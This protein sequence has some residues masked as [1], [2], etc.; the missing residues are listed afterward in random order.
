[1]RII[2][3]SIFALFMAAMVPSVGAAEPV[4]EP[5]PTVRDNS[6]QIIEDYYAALFDREYDRALQ[7]AKRLKPEPSNVEGRAL[8]TAMRAN[9][10]LGLG[11]RAEADRLIAE[12]K[13]LG[14]KEPFPVTTLFIG[15]MVANKIDVAADA[16]DDL[17]AR[18]PDV[19]REQNVEMVGFFLRDE[20]KGEV[21]RNEDRRIALARLGYGGDT[22]NGHLLTHQAIK[23]LMKRGDVGGARNLIPYL[24]EPQLME[25]LLIQKRFAAL[26]PDL[27]QAAGPHLSKVQE[28]LVRSAQQAYE[29]TPDD[30]DRLPLYANA[31]RHAGRLSDAIALRSKLPQTADEMS[32]ADQQMG[33]AVNNIAL[34]L[35]DAGRRDE[36]DR[37]FALLNDAPMQQENWRV[38]MKINRL[39]LLVADGQFERAL[40]L[41]EPTAKV[42][43]SP[44][45]EQL[46]RRLRYCVLSSLDRRAEAARLLPD[47]L[48]HAKDAYAATIDGLLCAG[49]VERA[50]KVALEALAGDN[51]EDF[52]E[53]F[54][55][56][57]QPVL[58]TG[59]TQPS[60]QGRWEEFRKRP[61]I[62]AEYA[63]LGRDMPSH[64]VP[65]KDRSQTSK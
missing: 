9:A 37:M 64:L 65:A 11:S 6:R 44:Y 35:H 40:P 55:R 24:G 4:I 23:L 43:G 18:F 13:Q 32:E 63:R 52:E 51:K 54:V 20:P 60:W 29:Q 58:L 47:M 49:E 25:N 10:L 19:M 38:S 33:W 61:A 50:E 31:L 1:M 8:V 62:A 26:W 17:I 7:I 14:S 28:N 5:T 2:R 48:S 53:E 27:Q 16:I 12:I 59:D 36:A 42:K 41:V 46:V 21:R 30:H 15:G 56:G 34:A 57:L 3:L 39:E 45:A 22:E